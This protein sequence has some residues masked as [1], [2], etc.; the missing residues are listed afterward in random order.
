MT[1]RFDDLKGF[2][3]TQYSRFN[4]IELNPHWTNCAI[5]GCD[6][7]LGFSIPMYEGRKVDTTKTD[8]WAGIPVCKECHDKDVS[9]TVF[10][11]DE[12]EN[13]SDF[14]ILFQKAQKELSIDGFVS[15]LC[16]AYGSMSSSIRGK[17]KSINLKVL[18]EA[19]ANLKKE[20]GR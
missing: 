7:P 10:G 20:Y 11:E 18:T 15:W 19:I 1:K 4:I 16:Q 17:E 12:E 6:T 9:E 2:L 14:Q 3:S 5:C 13:M 8:E